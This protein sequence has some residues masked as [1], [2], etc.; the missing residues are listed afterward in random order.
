MRSR[1]HTAVPEP[2][3]ACALRIVANTHPLTKFATWSACFDIE[4]TASPEHLWCVHLVVEVLPMS[5]SSIGPHQTIRPRRTTSDHVG[6][7]HVTSRQTTSD[8]VKCV[9]AR[10]P[11]QRTSA[12]VSARQQRQ[13]ASMCVRPHQTASASQYIRR[14]YISRPEP[15]LT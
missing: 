10:Q 6:P 4:R 14:L 15:N 1:N 2:P 5:T 12:H 9:S 3:A 7:R 13:R 8:H 11:R